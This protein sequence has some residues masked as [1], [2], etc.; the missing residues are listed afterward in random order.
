MDMRCLRLRVTLQRRYINGELEA[1]S[2]LYSSLAV[3]T[4]VISFHDQVVQTIR[5]SDSLI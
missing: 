2:R 5:A 3:G 4:S 1:L